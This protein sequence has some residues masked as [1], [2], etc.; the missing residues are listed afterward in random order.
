MEQV[1]HHWIVNE[2]EE[3][4]EP[5]DAASKGK[6]SLQHR[7]DSII[8]TA[9]MPPFSTVGEKLLLQK[10]EVLHSHK[11][12]QKEHATQK[13][14]ETSNV[15]GND[16][17]IN[18]D[19]EEVG[20]EMLADF[21]ENAMNGEV[22]SSGIIN[23][24]A[25]HKKN[26]VY[27][28]K[29]QGFDIRVKNSDIQCSPRNEVNNQCM[30]TVDDKAPPGSELLLLPKSSEIQAE[31][32]ENCGDEISAKAYPNMSEKIDQQL[33]ELDVEA[34]LS[35]Q[36]THDLFCPNCKSCITKRVI[37]RKRK[38]NIP[39]IDTIAKRDKLATEMVNSSVDEANQVD[40]AIATTTDVG[41][42]DPPADN[43]EPEREP[44]VFRCL[45]CFS[46]F[47]PMRNEFKLFPSFGGTHKPETSQK[48]S[49]IPSSNVEKENPS[50]VV[51]ASNA[52]WLLALFTSN[53]GRKASVQ[54]DA[55]IE[56]SRTDP[57]S[58]EDSRIDNP[59]SPL[60]NTPNQNV[61]LTSDIKLGN[62]GVNSPIPSV[63][64]SVVKIE[65]WIEK[66]KKSNVALPN[67]PL[68]DQNDFSTGSSSD[69]VN[70]LQKVRGDFSATKQL[71]NEN[72]RTDLGDKNRDSVDV[73]KTGIV[74]DISKRE[75][76]LVATVATTE[77]L[78]DAGK[79]AKDSILKSYEGSHI[80]D[81]SQKDVDKTLEIAQ[82]S[83]SSSMEE[84]QSP[85]Q[86][87]GGSVAANDVASEKP[88][89]RVDATIPSNQDFKEVLKNVEEEIKPSVAKEKEETFITSTSQTADSIPIEGAIVTEAH[90]E[91]YIGEQPRTEIDEHQEWEILKSIV[92]GGLVESITSLGVVS[93]AVAS[94]TAPLNVLA[95][96]LAN[97]IGGL[98]VIGHNLID[99]KNDHSGGDTLQM[100]VQDRY[101]ELLGHRA[102]FL[103][104]VVVAIFSFLI[105]GSVPLVVYGLLISKNYHAEVKIAAVAAASV[106]CI[107]VLAI[108]KVYTNRPLKSYV[109]T[110]LHYVSLAL[111]TSGISYLAGDLVKDLLEKISG[112]ESGSVLTMPLSGTRMK[113]AWMSY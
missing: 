36:E 26:S 37:L 1:H 68:V 75:G 47:I 54:G 43:Y 57:A 22:I 19:S 21:V 38:R 13:V 29:Q 66:G 42:V 60:A 76:V 65:S 95:V 59:E 6:H 88:S 112:S 63:V 97:L 107:I 49:V 100:N 70:V 48:P 3:E 82:D 62:V 93:S 106:V 89:S 58:I 39:N 8:A 27:S 105:F 56:D 4:E 18:G 55:S 2:E 7:K 101:Q 102:N 98:F 96:G 25:S 78:L 74:A 111:A 52:N 31:T 86:S 94:G 80:F 50:I 16:N 69:V 108:G 30:E 9:V 12:E 40:H 84:A 46:F 35:K 110:V 92:Y 15:V 64:K 79:P 20:L 109:K 33:K 5:Q 41:R 24:A 23:V 17:N 113:P 90:T 53:K 71:L 28:D 14:E 103:L 45:S 72:V 73:I 61:N 91:I 87:F 77:I 83:Y 34:V 44:E 32:V 10:E 85:A 99:L 67:E 104:H 81:K 11:E 51:A